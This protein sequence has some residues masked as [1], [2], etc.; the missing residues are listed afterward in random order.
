MFDKYN[1][2]LFSKIVD[3]MSRITDAEHEPLPLH[4]KNSQHF[5]SQIA[6]LSDLR[7]EMNLFLNFFITG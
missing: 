6:V 7:G 1:Y 4:L 3:V 2:F 5:K